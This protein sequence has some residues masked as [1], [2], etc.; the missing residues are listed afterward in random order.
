MF[1]EWIHAKIRAN[2]AGMRI[3]F[4]SSAIWA[5]L[6]IGYFAENSRRKKLKLKTMKTETQEFLSKN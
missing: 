1:R 5:G 6:S 4:I 3:N 2:L